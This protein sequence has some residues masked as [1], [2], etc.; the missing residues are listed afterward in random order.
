MKTFICNIP[1]DKDAG[2]ITFQTSLTSEL[3]QSNIE[4][5]VTVAASTIIQFL[6]VNEDDVVREPDFFDLTPNSISTSTSTHKP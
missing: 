5:N 3:F 2:I 1:E 4:L 6:I